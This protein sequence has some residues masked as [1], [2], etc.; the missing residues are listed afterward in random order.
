MCEQIARRG[1][2]ESRAVAIGLSDACVCV[3][4]HVSMAA[5]SPTGNTSTVE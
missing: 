3:C 5:T 1:K 2:K 4:V